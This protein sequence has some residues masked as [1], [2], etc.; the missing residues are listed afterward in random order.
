MFESNL[1]DAVPISVICRK[2]LRLYTL[3]VFYLIADKK[4][5]SKIELASIFVRYD[6]DPEAKSTKYRFHVETGIASLVGAMFIDSYKKGTSEY[7]YLTTYGEAAHEM[8]ADLIR[9]DPSILLGSK[10]VAK[11]NDEMNMTQ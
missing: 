4:N 7:Y 10:V 8:I 9:E 11:L 1:P 3:D 5:I 6:E 2:I